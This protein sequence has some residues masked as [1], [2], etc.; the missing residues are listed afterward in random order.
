MA[1]KVLPRWHV[2]VKLKEYAGH[3]DCTLLGL[4]PSLTLARNSRHGIFLLVESFSVS[5]SRQTLGGRR[6]KMHQKTHSAWQDIDLHIT[7][8]QFWSIRY[9]VLSSNS[10]FRQIVIVI[11]INLSMWLGK[12]CLVSWLS[13][14]QLNIKE[15]KTS[16]CWSHVFYC[17]WAWILDISQSTFISLTVLCSKTRSSSSTLQVWPPTR[18]SW[19]MP[20]PLLL[21][22]SFFTSSSIF[23]A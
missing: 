11:F 7:Q 1:T 6:Q 18:R 8:F 13:L 17:P 21:S 22:L 2:R 15:H 4:P 19:S 20:R 14:L 9:F 16:S 23:S 10:R 5:T 12:C 3:S